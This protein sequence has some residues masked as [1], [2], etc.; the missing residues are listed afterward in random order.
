MYLH[1][2]IPSRQVQHDAIKPLP[3]AKKV[4]NVKPLVDTRL[5]AKYLPVHKPLP[6]T[7]FD[8]K[9]NSSA[10]P[11][12]K[13]TAI[14]N[15]PGTKKTFE[16]LRKPVNAQP[17]PNFHRFVRPLTGS[18]EVA[19]DNADKVKQPE[20]VLESP[21]VVLNA[22]QTPRTVQFQ[23]PVRSSA[24]IRK[25]GPG[26]LLLALWSS[27][28]FADRLQH[29]ISKKEKAEC[30]AQEETKS[31]VDPTGVAQGIPEVKARIY[32]PDSPSSSSDFSIRESK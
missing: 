1:N 21:P 23:A 31:K 10:A 25:P 9:W 14:E 4:Y 11:D 18:T 22:N 8:K 15:L 30:F 28:T 27:P 20:V 19:K 13:S 3:G 2:R 5:N 6:S 26:H 29:H 32:D 7:L 24:G 17:V 16:T 12:R